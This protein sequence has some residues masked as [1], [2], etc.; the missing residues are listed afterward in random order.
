MII[1]LFRKF[2]VKLADDAANIY[3]LNHNLELV[4]GQ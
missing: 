1:F 4:I 3:D 2:W